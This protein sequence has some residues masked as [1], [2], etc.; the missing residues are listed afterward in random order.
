MKLKRILT[1]ALAALV[2][3]SAMAISSSAALFTAV[4]PA[5]GGKPEDEAQ[6]KYLPDLTGIDIEKIEMIQFDVEVDSGYMNGGVGANTIAKDSWDQSPQIDVGDETVTEP[7]SQTVAWKG[8]GGIRD[9]DSLGF[10]IWWINPVRGEDPDGDGP[11][12]APITGPGT[13]KITAT[14]FYDADGNVLATLPAA[15]VPPVEEDNSKDDNNEDTTNAGTGIESVAAI[16]AVA[17]IAGGAIVATRK[18]K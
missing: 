13:V 6:Q 9:A 17:L 10:Q 12:E 8:I 11:E 7:A 2:A 5:E 4:S 1:S 14:R 18:R 16:S 15:T 3:V